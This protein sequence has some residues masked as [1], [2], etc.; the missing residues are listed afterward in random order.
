MENGY[1]QTRV[2]D[3]AARAGLTERTFFR[4]FADKREVLFSQDEELLGALL[5]G[6][7]AAPE[8][9]TAVEA[10]AAGA[11][12]LAAVLQPERDALRRRQQVIEGEAE[13][14]ERDAAKQARWTACMAE[15]LAG[16]GHRPAD[17]ALAAEVVGG[18]LRTAYREW[19]AD[20]APTRLATRL[21][22]NL[23]RLPALLAPSPGR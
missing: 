5:D 22:G 16:R 15:R 3:V 14:R 23:D 1:A 18:C 19:L 10:A 21:A 13:L 11:V 2:A 6:I 17:A 20:R 8:G 12:A 7:G 4:H 9:A